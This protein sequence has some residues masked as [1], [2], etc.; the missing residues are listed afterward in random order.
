MKLVAIQ[1][2]TIDTARQA[3]LKVT[4]AYICGNTF[5]M[6]SISITARKNLRK[7]MLTAIFIIFITNRVTIKVR[8]S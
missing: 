2:T 3:L 4:N 6:L 7:S 5:N 8:I 1:G